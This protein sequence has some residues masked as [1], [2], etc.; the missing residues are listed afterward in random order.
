MVTALFVVIVVV[1]LVNIAMRI[2]GTGLVWADEVARFSFVWMAF[3]GAALAVA[4]GRHVAVTTL[5]DKLEPTSVRWLHR[6]LAVMSFAF[7]ALLLAIGLHQSSVNLG[8][9]SPAMQLPMAVVYAS[10]P[11]GAICMTLSLVGRLWLHLVDD[12]GTETERSIDEAATLG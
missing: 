11:V 7:F 2:G 3:L 6:I 4:D 5:A 10:V 8:N 12:A 9:L 1:S